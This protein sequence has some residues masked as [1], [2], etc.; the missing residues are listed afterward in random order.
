MGPNVGGIDPVEDSLLL[1]EPTSFSLQHVS[2]LSLALRGSLYLAQAPLSVPFGRGGGL[3][4]T[5]A[6]LRPQTKPSGL[7]KWK[8]V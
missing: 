6:W 1:M 2:Y 4:E 7:S 5:T 8:P 3:A